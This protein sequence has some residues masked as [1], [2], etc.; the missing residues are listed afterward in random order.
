MATKSRL[1]GRGL[2]GTTLRYAHEVRSATAYLATIPAMELPDELVSV[3]EELIDAKLRHS[4]AAHPFGATSTTSTRTS[5]WKPLLTT[6]SVSLP[7]TPARSNESIRSA[8]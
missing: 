6:V 1:F 4:G 2:C 5:R 3:A 7:P 8:H